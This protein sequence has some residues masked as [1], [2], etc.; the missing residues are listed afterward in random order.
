MFNISKES[1][2]LWCNEC[3]IPVTKNCLQN[4][5]K[6]ENYSGFLNSI[7]IFV[8]LKNDQTLM[9]CDQ[10]LKDYEEIQS[11]HKVILGW[12]HQLQLDMARREVT[13][14]GAISRLK[15]LKNAESC[16]LSTGFE[17]A[18]SAV[19]R[20]KLIMTRYSFYYS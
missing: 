18:G 6:T 10:A 4:E 2:I 9:I 13:C 14:T 5:H 19:S 17:N 16:S 1:E 7:G 12:I 20:I 15:S 3:F 11:Y 8:K